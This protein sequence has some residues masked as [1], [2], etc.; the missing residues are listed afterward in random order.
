[1]GIRQRCRRSCFANLVA[2]VSARTLHSTPL[3]N[4]FDQ[5]GTSP[6]H[7]DSKVGVLFSHESRASWTQRPGVVFQLGT[8][9]ARWSRGCGMA[10]Q[11]RARN[12][13]SA[14]VEL[15]VRTLSALALSCRITLPISGMP[16][17][18]EVVV[19][20][21][22]S[23]AE[24]APTRYALLLAYIR[25]GRTVIK[26]YSYSF[27]PSLLHTTSRITLW[28]SLFGESPK[29]EYCGCTK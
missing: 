18:W 4:S 29:I 21:Q 23:T 19:L 15:S 5:L 3:R 9:G 26:R 14:Y 16:K 24:A 11:S 13:R 17:H 20:L 6:H 27:S 1:M 28:T 25:G 8:V 22:I 7:Q 2:T 12:H 10:R